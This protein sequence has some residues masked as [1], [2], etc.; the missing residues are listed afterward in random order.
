LHAMGRLK[1]GVTIEQ[2]QANISLVWSQLLNS[3][4]VSGLTDRQRRN[5]LGQTL[6]VHPGGKGAN[7]LHDDFQQPLFVLM[8]LVPMVLLIACATM[9]TLLL[10]R[11]TAREKEIA[12]R[13]AMGASRLRL[14]MQ[15]ITESLLLAVIGGA[16]SVAFAAWGTRILLHLVSQ[17]P[18]GV[19]L[20]V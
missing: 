4:Q 5:Q 16:A 20:D 6:K 14:G 10:A 11:A 3:Y 1:P 7:S 18:D 9:A 15:L 19:P 8:T 17:G 12:V 2:A 13:L